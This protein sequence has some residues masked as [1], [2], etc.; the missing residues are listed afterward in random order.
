MEGVINCQAKAGT[1]WKVALVYLQPTN[2][3][4]EGIDRGAAIDERVEV[5]LR[6]GQEAAVV[7]KVGLDGAH[8]GHGG[9]ARRGEGR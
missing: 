3:V 9:T 7:V 5:R 2:V 4:E 1:G 6:Q 8:C